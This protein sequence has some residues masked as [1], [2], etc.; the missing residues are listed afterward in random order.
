MPMEDRIEGPVLRGCVP[1]V[2]RGSVNYSRETLSPLSPIPDLPHQL[3]L[4]QFSETGLLTFAAS[5]DSVP[6]PSPFPPV[7]RSSI[8]V[9]TDF[10]IGSKRAV[11][12]LRCLLEN[13]T[14][15]V[16]LKRSET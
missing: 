14:S 11:F 16:P 8:P 7:T 15:N 6:L 2:E 9:G 10:C 1:L 5:R 4:T 3:T 13:R 12:K